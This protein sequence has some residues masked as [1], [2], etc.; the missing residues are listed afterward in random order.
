MGEH[1]RQV[2]VDPPLIRPRLQATTRV[3]WA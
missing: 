3:L 1:S 2:L